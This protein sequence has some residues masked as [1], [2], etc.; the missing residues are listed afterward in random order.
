VDE[1]GRKLVTGT[2][3]TGKTPNLA[4]QS[5]CAHPSVSGLEGLTGKDFKE[6]AGI[7]GLNNGTFITTTLKPFLFPEAFVGREH[8]EVTEVSRTTFAREKKCSSAEID[9]KEFEVRKT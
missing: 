3:E 7:T 4:A 2:G 9:L 5:Q 1:H 8:C 6:R